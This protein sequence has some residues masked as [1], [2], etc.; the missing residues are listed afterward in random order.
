[1]GDKNLRKQANT[2][3]IVLQ[4]IV[5]HDKFLLQEIVMGDNFLQRL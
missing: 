5:T 4:K 2:A 3:S 1:M